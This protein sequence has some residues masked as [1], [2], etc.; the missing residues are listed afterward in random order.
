MSYILRYTVSCIALF[1]VS[2]AGTATA[3]TL[4]QT[5]NGVQQ[6]LADDEKYQDFLVP[7]GDS[8]S[9]LIL[10]AK[11]ADGGWI[12]YSYIDRFN[13][14][15]TQRVQAGEGATVSASYQVGTGLGAIPP[16]SILRM[17]IGKR[18]QWAKYDLLPE[19]SFGAGAGGGTAVL[20]STDRGSRWSILMVAGGGG[21]G[22]VQNEKG[23]ITF[24][25]GLPGSAEENGSSGITLNMVESGGIRG[26][27]GASNQPS[28]G[29][30]GAFG[31]GKH[32]NGALYYGN[33]GW[34]DHN[35]SGEPLGGIGGL[36]DGAQNGGWGFGGGGSGAHSGGGGGGYSGGGAGLPGHG[37]GGGGSYLEQR[38][39]R[40]INAGKQQHD[41]TNNPGDGYIRYLL[42]K[43]NPGR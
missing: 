42:T 27:G 31:D 40:P 8:I 3:Q 23:K 17:L 2:A 26:D 35:L 4:L 7:G 38:T 37:G 34:K 41:Y 32:E 1:L 6:V 43:K 11:G 19:G 10:E 16:G 9:M 36:H 12:E 15:R 30:G 21:G 28:G 18:G 24:H 20:L 25:P 14:L 29:G 39:V 33:A 13:T 5:T 22:G